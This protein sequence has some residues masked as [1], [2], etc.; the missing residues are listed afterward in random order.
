MGW[1]WLQS[2]DRWG[3]PG[4]PPTPNGPSQT[5]HWLG[6]IFLGN[7]QNFLCIII[8]FNLV[9]LIKIFTPNI[10][11]GWTLDPTPNRYLSAIFTW[12]E[13]KGS[14]LVTFNSKPFQ[15]IGHLWKKNSNFFFLCFPNNSY[16]FCLKLSPMWKVHFLEVLHVKIA[17]KLQILN[18]RS[19]LVI[20]E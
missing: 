2:Q 19:F 1:I 4:A 18:V 11:G 17:K 7:M 10:P 15:S 9:N 3:A 20:L 16:V 12:F 13:I 5:S 6:L 14:P 8:L